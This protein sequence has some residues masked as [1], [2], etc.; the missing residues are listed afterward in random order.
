MLEKD[1]LFNFSHVFSVGDFCAAKAN[2]IYCAINDR[3]ISY[4]SVMAVRS[5][6]EAL[7]RKVSIWS[8]QYAANDTNK[9]Y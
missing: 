9:F 4:R 8:I 1:F 5:F 7:A 2:L 6:A 3:K